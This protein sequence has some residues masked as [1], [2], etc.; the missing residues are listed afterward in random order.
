[1]SS[2]VVS[3]RKRQPTVRIGKKKD[4]KTLW[5][6]VINMHCSVTDQKNYQIR[7]SDSIYGHKDAFLRKWDEVMPGTRLK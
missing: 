4:T 6:S 7:G 2:T 5:A 1:M 3:K